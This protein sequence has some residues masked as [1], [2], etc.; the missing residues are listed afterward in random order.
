VP[1]VLLRKEY[2]TDSAGAGEYRGGAAVIKDSLWLEKADHWSVPLHTKFTSGFGVY[3]GTSGS[4]AAVWMFEPTAFDVR[5]NQNILPV[6]KDVYAGS[7]PIAGLLDPQTKVHLPLESFFILPRVRFG[8]L[9]LM[10]FSV[11]KRRVAEA[12]AIL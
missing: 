10:R 8:T 11:I 7:T 4:M 2:V 12:G 5:K 6:N 3:G 1:I 9:I